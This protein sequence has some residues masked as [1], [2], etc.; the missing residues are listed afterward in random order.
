[1]SATRWRTFSTAWVRLGGDA[2]PGMGLERQDVGLVQHDVEAIEV[3]GEAAHL[4][5]VALADHDDMVAVAREGRD[6]AM[7]DV[8]ERARC[9]DDPQAEGPRARQG[10]VGRAVGGD[11]QRRRPDVSGVVRNGDAPGLEGTQHGGVVN[12]VAEDGERPG[13]GVLEGER[14][15]VADA[16][17]H[18]EVGGAEDTHTLR[19]KVYGTTRECQARP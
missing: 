19:C 2:D 1:M 18:A 7:R 8:D 14:D 17:A 10:P 13:V 11:H 3:A 15:R 5:V 9:L 16:E 4:H 12:Q 6:G